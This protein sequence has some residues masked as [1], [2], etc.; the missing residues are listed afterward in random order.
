MDKFDESNYVGVEL[1]SLDT[2]GNYRWIFGDKVKPFCINWKTTKK[3]IFSQLIAKV[4]I[5]KKQN[6]RMVLVIQDSFS[7]YLN[8]TDSTFDRSKDLYILSVH[9]DGNSMT[10]VSM[11]SLSLEEIVSLMLETND[12]DLNKIIY[13]LNQ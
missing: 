12:I 8:I 6:K 7:E 11:Y 10:D 3:T 2:S 13:E 4:N 1:Q 9:Y 5:F